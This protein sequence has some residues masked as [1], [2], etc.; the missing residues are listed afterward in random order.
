M[1]NSLDFVP[2]ENFSKYKEK[3]RYWHGANCWNPTFNSLTSQQ[4]LSGNTKYLENVIVLF[5]LLVCF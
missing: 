4:I 3:G 5:Y 2:L 1:H